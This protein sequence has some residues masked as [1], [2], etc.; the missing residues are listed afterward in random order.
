MMKRIKRD[1]NGGWNVNVQGHEWW[2]AGLIG[3][4]LA[5]VFTMAGETLVEDLHDLVTNSSKMEHRVTQLEQQRAAD[6]ALL[7]ELN[8]TMR[9]LKTT[10]KR[11]VRALENL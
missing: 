2:K 11:L 10:Q 7:I 1:G 6:R 9:A 8:A 4:F 5:G 3:V